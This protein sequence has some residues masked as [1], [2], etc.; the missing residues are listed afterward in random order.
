[1]D[2]QES[3]SSPLSSS[4]P[5]WNYLTGRVV[6]MLCGL[7]R[8][9]VQVM[10]ADGVNLKA[11]CAS[12]IFE[13][14]SLRID[15]PVV[16][17][18]NAHDVLIGMAGMWPGKERWNRWSGR[19]V[20]VGPMDF[21]PLLTVKLQGKTCTLTSSGPVI[22]QR[23]RLEAWEPVNIVIDPE[24]VALSPYLQATA[25]GPRHACARTSAIASG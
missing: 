19:I 6:S 9:T 17:R 10:T 12:E 18:I 11:R 3:S 22:G 24:N 2:I 13:E 15:Q 25:D 5:R 1:M 21:A 14:M 8:T 20:L 4:G 7:T 23:L 16:A